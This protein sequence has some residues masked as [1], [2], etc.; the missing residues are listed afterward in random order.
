MDFEVVEMSDPMRPSVMGSSR[1]VLLEPIE[2]PFC[3]V[4]CS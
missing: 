3:S 4:L 1:D 2:G